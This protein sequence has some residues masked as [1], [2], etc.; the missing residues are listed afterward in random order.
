MHQISKVALLLETSTH[1]GRG[2][3]RG[4]IRCSRLHG[5]WSLYIGAGGFEQALPN[6]KFNGIIARIYSLKLAQDIMHAGLP[7]VVLEPCTEELAEANPLRGFS[8][9]VTDSSKIAQAAAE[10][11]TSLGLHSFAFCGYDN[12]PW[13]R[14]RER[15]FE[16][17]ITDTGFPC[18]K[19][20]INLHNWMRYDNC[21]RACEC[22][23]LTLVRWVE[24]LPQRT[25]L[26]VCNDACGRQVLQACADAGVGV[27][28]SVAI[29]GVD[30]DELMCELSVPPLSVP[31]RFL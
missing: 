2:L 29:I 4:I 23:R 14:A 6:T 15:A 17:Y 11:L 3:L 9:I 5:P 12:C 1:Y 22:E 13:S 19:H 24:S 16:R 8:E 25:G 21:A 27:P 20:R 31:S 18:L 26:M 7:A 28:A 30:N 10:H